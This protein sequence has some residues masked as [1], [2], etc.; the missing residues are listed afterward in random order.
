MYY[1]EIV[2]KHSIE[3]WF[4]VELQLKSAGQVWVLMYSSF[5]KIDVDS[6]YKAWNVQVEDSIVSCTEGVNGMFLMLCI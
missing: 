4:F 1:L 5:M 2:F 6:K 3:F